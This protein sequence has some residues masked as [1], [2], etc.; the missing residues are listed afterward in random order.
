MS[1]LLLDTIISFRSVC[2]SKETKIKLVQFN[3]TLFSELPTKMF[4]SIPH[5]I[6]FCANVVLVGIVFLLH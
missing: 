3:D 4:S 5:R 2:E 1:T 6:Y